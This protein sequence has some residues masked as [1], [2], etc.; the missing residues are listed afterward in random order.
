MW[1]RRGRIFKCV[2]NT[3]LVNHATVAATDRDDELA[4]RPQ[5]KKTLSTGKLDGLLR[6]WTDGR[7]M[8]VV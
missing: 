7:G 4:E 6:V 8:N 2:D 1:V 5:K 3:P